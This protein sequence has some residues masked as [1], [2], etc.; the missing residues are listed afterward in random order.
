MN[1]TRIFNIINNPTHECIIE[2][3]QYFNR[4]FECNEYTKISYDDMKR[5]LVE[6]VTQQYCIFG[7]DSMDVSDVVKSNWVEISFSD[8]APRDDIFLLLKQSGKI[9]KKL[10]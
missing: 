3:L 6:Y 10:G 4:L 5:A 1:K 2:Q 7:T 8:T 9:T